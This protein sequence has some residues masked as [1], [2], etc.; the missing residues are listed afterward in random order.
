MLGR[1]DA[2][3]SGQIEAGGI[4]S[5]IGANGAGKSTLLTIIGRL[6][7][8]PPDA[9]MS[10]GRTWRTPRRP[11]AKKLAI[12]RQDNHTTARLRV[13]ELVAMGRFLHSKGRLRA[14]DHAAVQ[15]APEF[16]DLTA[17]ADRFIDQMSGGSGSGR[18]SAWCWRRTPR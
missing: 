15:Q 8:P 3:L 11:L 4:T 6:L 2:G 7:A 13:R 12:L 14:E 16:C 9:S 1:P 18:S 10:A 17:L 5:I